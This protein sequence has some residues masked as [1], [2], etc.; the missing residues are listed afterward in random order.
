MTLEFSG[1]VEEMNSALRRLF[2]KTDASGSCQLSGRERSSSCDCVSALELAMRNDPRVANVIPAGLKMGIKH[3]LYQK[4]A[5]K[6]QPLLRFLQLLALAVDTLRVYR[7]AWGRI[8]FK[9]G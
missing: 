8:D 2:V 6:R 7:Q 1:F 5:S 9:R 4:W 3:R